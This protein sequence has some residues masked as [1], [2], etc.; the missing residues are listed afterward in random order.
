MSTG[1]G[2]DEII[3]KR[4][5]IEGDSGN[6]DRV[7]NKLIRNF[8]KWIN[9]SKTLPEQ[10]ETGTNNSIKTNEENTNEMYEQMMVSL[11]HIEFSLL[12]NQFIC[13][14]NNTEQENYENLYQKI[15]NEIERAKKKIVESKVDLQEARKIRKNRQEYDILAKQ[16]LTYPNRLEM[17]LTI[18]NLE[19][20]L[21]N[22]KKL[23]VE[24]GRKLELRRKQFNFVLYSLN[25]L[26]N[27]IETDMK[28]DEYSSRETQVNNI[29]SIKSNQYEKL[30]IEERKLQKMEMQEEEM[31]T[32][33]NA[34]TKREKHFRIPEVPE[35]EMEES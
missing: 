13:E 18:K 14:M 2:E 20:R 30:L 5:L 11:S 31:D 1:L 21:E 24:Y 10:K 3:K 28:F 25:S 8:V 32:E 17:L 7:I 27:L 29:E 34:Y 16:I 19:E 26:K 33:T 9:Q 22:F 23:E 6:D 12:R 4:L 35:V 15:N